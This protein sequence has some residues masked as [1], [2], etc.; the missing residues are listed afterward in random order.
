MQ[1]K[2][3][4]PFLTTYDLVKT[5]ALVLM[6]L[7]HIGYFFYPDTLWLRAVGRGSFPIWCFL[8]GYANSRNTGRDIWSWATV[9][10]VFNMALGGPLLPLNILFTIIAVRLVL[11]RMANV[12]FRNWEVMLYAVLALTLLVWPTMIFVEY[13]AMGLLLALCGYAVRHQDSLGVSMSVQRG[14][15]FFVTVLYF[16]SQNFMFQFPEAEGK[17]A[18][19]TIG[20][21][22]LVMCFFKPL[23]LIDWTEKLPRPITRTLQFS[24]RYTMEIY[25]VH[26]IVFK[27]AAAI[28]HLEG[29]GF[30]TPKWIT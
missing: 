15:I 21:A 16:L 6:I 3:S 11:D 9:L 25:V 17:I 26:L 27:L 29:Y 1:L 5:L 18:A 4:T 7:D 23:N 24:G 22:M 10:L 30:F 12:V 2:Y 13:G 28:Y 8:I 20:S 14:Y 19:F